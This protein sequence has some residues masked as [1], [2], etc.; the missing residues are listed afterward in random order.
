MKIHRKARRAAKM[1]APAI[2]PMTIP[3]IAPP[4]RPW[5]AAAAAVEVAEADGVSGGSV[6]VGTETPSQTLVALD[7]VQQVSFSF[8]Q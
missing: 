4:E 6:D 7:F 8:A 2:E 1:A 3:A 5:L